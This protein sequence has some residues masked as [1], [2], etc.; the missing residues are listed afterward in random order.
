MHPAFKGNK[1]R[2]DKWLWAARFYKTRGLAKAAIDGGRVHC[3]GQRVKASK[4][5]AVG[6]SLT[7]SRGV[8]KL[9]LAVTALTDQRRGA[10]EAALLYEETAES[11]QRR[12]ERVAERRAGMIGFTPGTGKP[13]K[14]DRRQLNRLR[15]GS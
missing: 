2:L 3:A 10:P 12:T 11:Q 6:D 9:E 1:V 13:T 7:I 14:K 8:D 15:R 5:I 4:E